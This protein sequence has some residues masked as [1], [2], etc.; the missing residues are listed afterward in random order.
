MDKIQIETAQNVRIT[1][2]VA[3]L[4]DRILAFILD[5]LAIAVYEMLMLLVY[6][7]LDLDGV[8]G[9]NNYWVAFLVFGLPVFLYHLLME[10]L[11][12][13]QSLG[14]AALKIRVVRLDGSSPQFSDYLIRWILRIIDISLTS[15][16][17]AIFTFLLNGKG[18][19]LG[20]ISAKTTVI[21]EKDHMGLRRKTPGI[22]LPDNY[23]PIYPQVTI[24][25]DKEM[26][27]IKD[28]YQ[29][30]KSKNNPEVIQSLAEKVARLMN[31]EA[32]GK[33][34]EFLKQVI[35]DYTYYTQQ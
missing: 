21:S 18:Q 20:D 16:A 3:G 5:G 7:S 30:A 9:G 1:H 19:R 17:M 23:M 34:A 28:L 31:V 14:K 8:F 32:T 27:A 26:Q 29:N 4:G 15:G 24:F 11:N 22:D 10:S 13:G 6:F 2:Q 33:S 25:T 12:N 35:R